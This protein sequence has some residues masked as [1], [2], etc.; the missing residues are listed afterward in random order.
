MSSYLQRVLESKRAYR[1]KLADLP[2]TEKL[3]LLDELRA[4]ALT[5]RRASA[6]APHEPGMVEEGQ[7]AYSAEPACPPEL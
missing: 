1:Q 7:T 5:L 6:T 3:H 4:T 2:V